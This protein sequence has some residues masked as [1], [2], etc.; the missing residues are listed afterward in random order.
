MKVEKGKEMVYNK[1]EISYFN[2]K[3]FGNMSRTKWKEVVDQLPIYL[4]YEENNSWKL[5]A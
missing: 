1:K 5:K 2:S 4:L 3:Q